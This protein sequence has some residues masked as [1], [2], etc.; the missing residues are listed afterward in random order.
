MAVQTTQNKT[1]LLAALLGAIF[2]GIVTLWVTKA[3]PKMMS[4]VMSKSMDDMMKKMDEG[5]FDP[6]S[7]CAQMMRGAAEAEAA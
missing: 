2:G 5:S 7:M 6:E 1:Y 3:L 4:S